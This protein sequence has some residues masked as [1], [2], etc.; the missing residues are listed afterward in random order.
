MLSRILRLRKELDDASSEQFPC[1]P[2]ILDIQ[3]QLGV[4]FREEESFWRLKK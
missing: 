2:E 1:W 4:A 3:R